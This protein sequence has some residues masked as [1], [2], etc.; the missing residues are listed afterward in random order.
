MQGSLK[1]NAV[2]ALILP[3]VVLAVPILDTGFVIAKR[4]K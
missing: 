4:I 2:V 3:L 1:T